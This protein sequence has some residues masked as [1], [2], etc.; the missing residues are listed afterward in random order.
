MCLV[1]GLVRY[2]KHL[3]APLQLTAQRM[4]NLFEIRTKN[5]ISRK[6]PAPQIHGTKDLFEYTPKP[7]GRERKSLLSKLPLFSLCPSPLQ[8]PHERVELP[9]VLRNLHHL[10]ELRELLP[11]LQTC[12]AQGASERCCRKC[13]NRLL[14][15]LWTMARLSLPHLQ[16]LRRGHKE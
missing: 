3:R 11:Y 4:K 14:R 2:K 10:L 8:T 12:M 9:H 5:S 6:G 16:I 7:L 13:W 1:T 15:G